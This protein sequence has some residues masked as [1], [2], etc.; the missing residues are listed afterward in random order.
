MSATVGV[1]FPIARGTTKAVAAIEDRHGTTR[2]SGE[3][4]EPKA[5]R[6]KFPLVK[7]V[8]PKEMGVRS[9][10]KSK[11]YTT[12]HSLSRHLAISL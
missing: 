7:G 4:Y 8:A 1:M 2:R 3:I 10:G 12:F 6:R 5:Q 9:V 11:V